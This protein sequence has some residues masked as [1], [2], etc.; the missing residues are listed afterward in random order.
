MSDDEALEHFISLDDSDILSTIKVW[1][2]SNDKWLAEL[3]KLFANRQVF[4]TEITQEA[5]SEEKKYL[6]MEHQ[7][8]NKS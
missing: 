6:L 5:T 1:A 2:T 3:C 8:M 7:K 4:H